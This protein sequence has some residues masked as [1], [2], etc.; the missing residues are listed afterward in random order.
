M[1]EIKINYFLNEDGRKDHILKGGNGKEMHNTSVEV[2]EEILLH[3]EQRVTGCG[4][5]KPINLSE[6][7]SFKVHERVN[8]NFLGANSQMVKHLDG[9]YFEL[10]KKL[11]DI[12]R[13]DKSI[14]WQV[15]EFF[16]KSE[17][18]RY[19]K[20]LDKE[21]LV[22]EAINHLDSKEARIKKGEEFEVEALNKTIESYKK[23][24][25]DNKDKINE[26]HSKI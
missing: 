20:V 13:E 23:F 9:E 25:L 5:V 11:Q 6:S 15:N 2:T 8:N 3:K 7:D 4:T 18:I 22:A 26:L 16:A 17:P 21:E 24:F 1:K 12:I 14:K 10:N 19:S